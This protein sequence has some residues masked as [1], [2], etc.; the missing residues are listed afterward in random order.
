MACE[1]CDLP[2]VERCPSVLP[3]GDEGLLGLTSCAELSQI[4]LS[5]RLDLVGQT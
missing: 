3:G 2:Q 1:L 5:S 4:L